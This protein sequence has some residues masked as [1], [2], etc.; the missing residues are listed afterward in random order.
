MNAFLS[1]IWGTVTGSLSKILIYTLLILLGI[2]VIFN[3]VHH[4]K[5]K[6]LD[7][8]ITQLIDQRKQLKDEIATR[9]SVIENQNKQIKDAA[10]KSKDFQTQMNKLSD[11]IKEHDKINSDLITHLKKQTVPN[12][13]DNT[14]KYLNDNIGIFKW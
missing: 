14:V 13:C 10:L 2:S 8:R 11:T 5:I 7:T 4:F 9:D 6:I 1:G 12:S 3:T